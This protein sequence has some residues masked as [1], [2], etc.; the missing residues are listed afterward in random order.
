M[1]PNRNTVLVIVLAIVIILAL[2][3]A[4]IL[5]LS[6]RQEVTSAT[7]LTGTTYIGPV[8]PTQ[9]IE[10]PDECSTKPISIEVVI[11]SSDGK[12]E[13]AR[14]TSDSEGKYRVNL[15]PGTYLLT[16]DPS[17]STPPTMLE[18]SVTIEEGKFT[19]A[20]IFFD[21]GIR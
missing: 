12:N 1:K 11:K 3:G 4:F 5:N 6:Q 2:G 16:Q 7:G 8:C 18:K 20:D 9:K 17:K 19:A 15:V 21:S 13:V 10:R 14:F